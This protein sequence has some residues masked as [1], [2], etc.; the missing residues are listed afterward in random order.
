[1]G[2]D[3]DPGAA[4]AAHVALSG[5]AIAGGSPHLSDGPDEELRAHLLEAGRRLLG[6]PRRAVRS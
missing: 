1:M 4:V 2:T 5:I 6:R 3:A